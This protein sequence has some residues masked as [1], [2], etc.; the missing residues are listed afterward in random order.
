VNIEVAL[1][2]RVVRSIESAYRCEDIASL[3][4]YARD[5]PNGSNR[6]ILVTEIGN[7]IAHPR[8]R[9]RG[10]VT[11]AAKD[12]VAIVTFNAH[13]G[14]RSGIDFDRLPKS[15]IAHM[16]AMT[17]CVE[18]TYLKRATGL[19][20]QAAAIQVA[21]SIISRLTKNG[22]GTLS[23]HASYSDHTSQ[24]RSDDQSVNEHD[25]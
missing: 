21:Q 7:A 9:K 1:R 2:A 19:K 5:P 8:G 22:D 25:G 6:S 15:F 18:P 20:S 16:K 4:I 10:P 3:L 13:M 12:L 14:K 11:N 17:R 24:G 23:L